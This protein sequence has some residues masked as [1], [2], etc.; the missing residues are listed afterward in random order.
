VT[1]AQEPALALHLVVQ[2]LHLT[3]PLIQVQVLLAVH[4][5]TVQ[6][7]AAHHQQHQTK[8]QEAAVFLL[9]LAQITILQA[10]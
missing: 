4:Q 2:I 7:R 3:H 6:V 1:T 9:L 8:A 5:T 10:V